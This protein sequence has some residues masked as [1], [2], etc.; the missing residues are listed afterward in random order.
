MNP[1]NPQNPNSAAGTSAGQNGVSAAEQLSPESVLHAMVSRMSP[2]G[3]DETDDSSTLSANDNPDALNNPAESGDPGQNDL[4]PEEQSQSGND[5]QDDSED[6]NALSQIDAEFTE[7]LKGLNADARKHLLELSEALANN[8]TSIGQLKRNLK[9]DRRENEEL[10]RLRDEVEQLR[11]ETAAAPTTQTPEGFAKFKTVEQVEK[12]LNEVRDYS[13]A[14]QDFLDANP[15]GP[16]ATYNMDGKEVTRSQLIARRAELRKELQ[17]LP[18][19]AETIK[20]QAQL[21]QQ[22]QQVTAQ[23][24]KDF[25]YLNDADHADTVMVR[26]LVRDP[27]FSDVPNAEFIA[28]AIVKGAKVL[29]AERKAGIKKP[30]TTAAAV[31]GKVPLGK[32]HTSAGPSAP[33]RT[34]PQ[35][36]PKAALERVRKEGSE[37]ALAALM[38]QMG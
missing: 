18:R 20:H 24:R 1:N 16:D 26:Q 36:N 21:Q 2:S 23:I 34:S 28:L 37:T 17:Q 9:L 4:P 6:Q 35:G 8:E 19:H 7:R 38:S 32:P 27:K 11:A 13:D 5:S 31:R 25:P 22:R 10:A 14:I 3:A 33:P 30:A 15:G 29:E 12:R